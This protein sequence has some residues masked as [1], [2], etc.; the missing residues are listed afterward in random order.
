MK[1]QSFATK[2]AI[3][4]HN[5]SKKSVITLNGVSG[6]SVYKKGEAS[7]EETVVLLYSTG[8]S[9][10]EFFLTDELEKALT[11]KFNN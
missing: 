1:N 7:T 5:P 10:P 4:F 11:E 2:E 9:S 8:M 6:Y 3:P